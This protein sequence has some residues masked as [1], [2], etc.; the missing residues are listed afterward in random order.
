MRIKARNLMR[1]VAFLVLACLLPFPALQLRT[2]A[3]ALSVEEETKAGEKFLA[4]ISKRFQ[5]LD[6]EF[7]NGYINELGLYLL[8]PVETKYF[9]FQFYLIRDNDLN[10]FAG[11]GGHIFF[12]SGLI[13]VMD[14]VDELA[15]VICH[16][17]GHVSARHLS[18]RIEQNKKIGLMTL[19]GVLAGALIGGKAGNAIVTGAAAAG[20]QAQLNY[21]REDERQADQLGFKYM[22]ASGFD[23][24][25]MVSTLKKLDQG[26]WGGTEGIPPYLRT[27]PGGPE[28]IANTEVMLSGYAPKDETPETARLRRLF[29]IFKTVLIAKSMEPQAAERLFLK[30]LE[31]DPDSVLAHFGLGMIWKERSEYDRAIV[32]F[33]KALDASPDALPILIN[34]GETYILKG[35]GREAVRILRRAFELDPKSGSALFLLG[36][37][38]LNLEDY[39]A[40]VEIF[41][42]LTSMKPI[43]D[44]VFYNLGVAYGRQNRLAAAHYNFGLHFKRSRDMKKARFHFEK[45]GEFSNQDPAFQARIREAL[46]EI[47]SK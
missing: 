11:P 32:F 25:G 19:A 12:F 30:D 9:P 47:S 34:L 4:Q 14:R 28:R 17:I 16:E 7:A 46:K 44:E 45:A 36:T 18:Q 38:Y 33:G 21:S 37:A 15:A 40:A 35:Q 3:F 39:P 5:M 41:E 26:R 13:E 42:R 23:P 8:R 29:P 6:D 43:R 20:M 27:H 2:D 22:D 1:S 10:A 31:R 24:A